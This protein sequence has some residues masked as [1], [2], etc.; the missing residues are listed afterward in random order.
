MDIISCGEIL[1]DM[2]SKTYESSLRN[3]KDYEVHIGGSPSNIA[4]NLSKQGFKSSIISKIGNDFFGRFI[5][6]N[7][8]KNGVETSLLSVDENVNTDI[9]FVLK[10]K[11]S[12]DFYPYRS[13]T[14]NMIDHN[15]PRTKIFHFSF[16]AL[17][18]EKNL[19]NTIKILNESKNAFIGF[20]PNYRKILDKTNKSIIDILKTILPKVNIIKPSEDDAESIFGKMNTKDYIKKFH[21]LGAKNIILTLGK[22]GYIISNGKKEKKYTSYAKEV[23]DTTGAGDAFWSGFYIGILNNL[24]IFEASKLGNAFSAEK[25]K[26]VGAVIDLKSYKEIAKEYEIGGIL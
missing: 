22:D 16:W 21:E 25:I 24:N 14:L 10:S 26:K 19:K 4:I 1:I 3:V 11:K 20:D 15:L 8:E 2:I 13:A 7:L 23:I 12:P 9:V 5:K 18:T 6:E 17:S